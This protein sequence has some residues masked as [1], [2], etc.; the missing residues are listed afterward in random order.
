VY[1]TKASTANIHP[2]VLETASS[3]KADI[4]KL[5]ATTDVRVDFLGAEELITISREPK[6]KTRMIG[7]TESISSDTGDSFVCLVTLASLVKFLSDEHGFLVRP[8]FDANVRDFLGKTEVN[9]AIKGTLKSLPSGDFW[10]F[11][12]GITIV[13]SRID[14]KGKTLALEDPLVV[15][16]LQTSNVIH[17][18]MNDQSIAMES[19]MERFD[20][21]VLVK[22]IVPGDEKTRDEVIKATNSQ[23]HIPKPYLRGMDKVHRNIEDHLK[24]V[25][26]FYERRKNQYKNLGKSR[27]EIATLGEM[28]QSLMSALLFRPADARGRPNSLLKSDDDYLSL[29]SED[30]DLDTF[31]NVI[32]AKRSVVE[33]I[34][35]IF[36]EATSSFRNDI[37]FHILAFLSASNFYSSN[38]AR[39]AWKG[40]I[41]SQTE[42]DDAVRTVAKLFESK[43]AT[44]RVAKSPEFQSLVLEEA[45][46]IRDAKAA[47]S[48]E[49]DEDEVVI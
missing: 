46:S 13:A 35:E 31:T 28:A 2:S 45:R 15:N 41:F 6:T 9:D 16:G 4:A 48:Q 22:I 49:P 44:D 30:F 10:W 23:T 25:G 19:R 21:I 39:S 24:G 32:Q 11:N 38:H 8:L 3:L 43:G 1:A 33:R 26:I 12:N 7:I 17:A 47:S 27:N 5:L 14:Q 40:K 20:N 18:F 29:F 42:I 36:P 37:V 34:V